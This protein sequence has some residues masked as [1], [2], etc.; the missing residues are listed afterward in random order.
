MHILSPTAEL[1]TLVK[2]QF[3]M[4]SEYNCKFQILNASWQVLSH[5]TQILYLADISLVI[6]GLELT[7]GCT[8][9]ESG[10]GSGSLTTSLARSIAPTGHVFTFDF[11]EGRAQSA[12]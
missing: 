9:L 8:V 4:M 5:R 2:A 7:P 10:T 3:Q 1:W 12:R 6:S 11:H